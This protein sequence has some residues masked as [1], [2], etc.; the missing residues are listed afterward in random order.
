MGER[1]N[2]GDDIVPP[3]GMTREQLLRFQHNQTNAALR[4]RELMEERFAARNAGK[5][6]PKCGVWRS[7]RYSAANPHDCDVSRGLNIMAATNQMPIFDP[8]TGEQA[9]PPLCSCSKCMGPEQPGPANRKSERVAYG[10]VHTDKVGPLS[11]KT[12]EPDPGPAVGSWF[13]DCTQGLETPADAV[14]EGPVLSGRLVPAPA[15]RANLA[16]L[17]V[18]WFANGAAAGWIVGYLVGLLVR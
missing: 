6:C 5:R 1:L 2:A 15:P 8:A 9:C 7:T 4:D 17:R 16:A 3:N 10:T 13:K 11:I 14:L 12:Y 18:A